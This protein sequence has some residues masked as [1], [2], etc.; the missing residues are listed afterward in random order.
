MLESIRRLNAADAEE[1]RAL[2]LQA[3]EE[4][5]ESF[6]SDLGFEAGQPLEWFARSL[7]EEYAFGAYVGGELSGVV[8][9]RTNPKKP[10]IIHRA[11]VW[12]VYVGPNARGRGVAR[13]LME[14]A[15][16][17]LPAE[18]EVVHL[19]VSAQNPSA[20]RTYEGLG[21]RRYGL[22]EKALKIDGRYV[23]EILMMRQLR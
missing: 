6:T 21:F 13:R 5:P 22:E 3:L 2:R 8:V 18:V 23:D 12:G 10:K 14:A 4:C 16:A 7:R 20:I 17:E 11:F 19:G 15:I 9:I 1:F